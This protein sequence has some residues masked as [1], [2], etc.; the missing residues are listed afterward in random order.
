MRTVNIKINPHGKS[1]KCF[2]QIVK[3]FPLS[4]NT[5]KK[6]VFNYRET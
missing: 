1:M 3:H 2:N 6:L 4:K 5:E